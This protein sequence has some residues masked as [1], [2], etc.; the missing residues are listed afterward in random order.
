MRYAASGTA[1]L[2]CAAALL[3]AAPALAAPSVPPVAPPSAAAPP[4]PAAGLPQAPAGAPAPAPISPA[5]AAARRAADAL[6]AKVDALQ[7]ATEQAVEHY[8]AVISDLHAAQTRHRRA[9]LELSRARQAQAAADRAADS[10]IRS[11]YISGGPPGLLDVTVN[12]GQGADLFNRFDD[13]RFV[14]AADRARLQVAIAAAA[15][16]AAAERALASALATQ[17]RLAAS[18]AKARKSVEAQLAAQQKLLA[19]ASKAVQQLLDA[20]RKAAARAAAALAADIRAA[21]ARAGGGGAAF[22][23][24][25]AVPALLSPFLRAVLGGAEAELGKPYQWGATGPV[26]YDCSGLVQHAFAAGGIALPRTS[27]AQW[28]AG[29]HPAGGDVQPGDLLF[30]AGVPGDASSI[31]HV[32]IYVGGGY[33]IAAPHTGTVVQVQPVYPSGFFGVTRIAAP[34]SH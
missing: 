7:V 9:A 34:T 17:R 33:M 22:S 25:S 12:G 19:G 13:A 28:L 3:T 6:Q 21:Q 1:A 23:T 11:L 27:R 18:A 30:W 31:H 2:A 26:S 8:N 16:S 5:V 29:S 10:R 24:G 32:A 14:V 20:E 4:T 15:R